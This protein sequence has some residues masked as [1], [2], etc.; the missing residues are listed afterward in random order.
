[1]AENI[2]EDLGITPEL[3]AKGSFSGGGLETQNEELDTEEQKADDKETKPKEETDASSNF[4]STSA[5]PAPEVSPEEKE[6]SEK[7][8]RYKARLNQLKERAA[9]TRAVWQENQGN[10]E[11]ATIHQ[12]RFDDQQS[13]I[14]DVIAELEKDYQNRLENAYKDAELREQAIAYINKYTPMICEKAGEFADWWSEQPKHFETMYG[15]YYLFANKQMLVDDFLD[16]TDYDKKVFINNMVKSMNDASA[17]SVTAKTDEQDTEKQGLDN[18]AAKA[19]DEKGTANGTPLPKV[20]GEP[21]ATT[22]PDDMD[23]IFNKQRK[24]H[25]SRFSR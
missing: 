25:V 6:A 10:K 1:M 13:E 9:K 16:M 20:D 5:T 12:A 24:A 19:K 14:D 11:L 2:K 21:P 3:E 17:S 18:K 7:R 8:S 15:L 23:A 4:Q 22:D